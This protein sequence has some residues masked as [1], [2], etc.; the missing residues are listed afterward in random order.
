MS[1]CVCTRMLLQETI[2]C[3][4]SV[5]WSGSD[6][7]NETSLSLS[8][9]YFL[10]IGKACLGLLHHQSHLPFVLKKSFVA[11][12]SCCEIQ[13]YVTLQAAYHKIYPLCS[14]FNYVLGLLGFLSLLFLLFLFI[15]TA[16]DTWVKHTRF[17]KSILGQEMLPLSSLQCQ[18]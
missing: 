13:F 3:C 1:L 10:L 2:L 11:I 6:T 5:N 16:C 4:S 15:Q 8:G 12:S 7:A 18:Y 14:S 17:V 9:N